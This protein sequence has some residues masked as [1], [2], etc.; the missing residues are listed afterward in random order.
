LTRRARPRSSKP[1]RR[2]ALGDARLEQLDARER[3]AERAADL[4]HHGSRDEPHMCESIRRAQPSLE[5]S[6]RAKI[7]DVYERRRAPFENERNREHLDGDFVTGSVEDLLLDLGHVAA[8]GVR[9][10]HALGDDVAITRRYEVEHRSPDDV[11]ELRVAGELQRCRVRVDDLVVAVNRDRVGRSVDQT[12]QSLLN[13]RLVD[14]THRSTIVSRS[15]AA[16]YMVFQS[17]L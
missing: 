9:L 5:L 4:V 17:T 12:L 7:T 3:V 11:G 16:G 13:A 2:C 10:E 8:S 6:A 15:H 14:R 1:T